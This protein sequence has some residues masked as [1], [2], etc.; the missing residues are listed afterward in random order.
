MQPIINYIKYPSRFFLGII[1]KTGF[2]YSDRIYLKLYYFFEMGKRL[3]LR[4]PKTFNEKLQWL[5]IYNRRPEYTKMVDKYEVKDYVASII[6][7]EYIIPTLGV[8]DKPEDIEWEKLPNQFV[9]KTTHGGGGSGVVICR[10]KLHFDYQEAIRKLNNSLNSDIYRSFREWPYKYVKKRV[11]VETYMNDSSGEL[12]DYKFFCFN[13]KVHFFKVDFN[14]FKCHQANYYD[15]NRNL[16]PFGEASFL[17]DPNKK[18]ILPDSISEMI[19][20][21]EKLSDGNPFMRIDFY[22]SFGKVYFGEITFFPAGGMGKFEPEEWDEKL[23]DLINLESV[24][25]STVKHLD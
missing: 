21:S 4:D 10:D 16:L 22:D 13:G 5:K 19:R 17:P 2:L 12:R 25:N 20:L 14:R 15:R 24:R 18:I 6:G 23:G 11:I 8:W 1:K 9:L 7:Q 3:N